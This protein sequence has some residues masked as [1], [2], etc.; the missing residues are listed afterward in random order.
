M[1]VMQC[2]PLVHYEQIKGKGDYPNHAVFLGVVGGIALAP[3]YVSLGYT[4]VVECVQAQRSRATGFK[5]S[6]V[7]PRVVLLPQQY[8]RRV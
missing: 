6:V 8:S 3:R 4:G 2:A 5:V 1:S 7:L